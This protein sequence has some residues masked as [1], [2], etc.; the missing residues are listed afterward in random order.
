MNY[1]EVVSSLHGQ[2]SSYSRYQIHSKTVFSSNCCY[3][4]FYFYPDR[5]VEELSAVVG[6]RQVR[7][8]DR[9]NLPYTDAVIHE[10]QR[11]ANIVPMAIPH[12]TSKDVTFQ[13]Y[14]IKEV[15]WLPL[16]SLKTPKTQTF[17]ELLFS[18]CMQGTT[19]LPLLTSVLYDESEWESPH[20]FNPSHFLDN[21]GKF[22]RRDAFMPFSAGTAVHFVP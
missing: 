19:V 10:S 6:S 15:R 4:R 18:F 3:G 13:G 14:F 16:P 7:I 21:E 17:V 5:V 2:V 8:E 9:K 1:F 22:I 20:T 11:L 12:T